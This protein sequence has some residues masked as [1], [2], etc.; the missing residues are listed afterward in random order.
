MFLTSIIVLAG[1]LVL[2]VSTL[3]ITA[4]ASDL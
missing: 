1:F 4:Y 3:F 2:L